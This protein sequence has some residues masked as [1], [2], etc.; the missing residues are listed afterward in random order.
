ML[1]TQLQS[2]YCSIA[3][4]LR[5]LDQQHTTQSFG[6]HEAR[7]AAHYSIASEIRKL[8]QRHTTHSFGDKEA[9]L[10]A[11]YSQLRRSGSWTS[12]TLHR[13]SEIRKL[14]Q[15][16]TTQSLRRSGNSTSA[17]YSIAS[18]IR[19]LHQRHTTQSFFRIYQLHRTELLSYGKLLIPQRDIY[20]A[21]TYWVRIF[22]RPLHTSNPV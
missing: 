2:I 19:K 13:A 21:Y 17:Y 15:Q 1:I 14:D 20:H 16:H 8:D 18:E 3:S 4:G 9:G 12:G 22:P 5:K 10:A 7:L 6:D 11:H